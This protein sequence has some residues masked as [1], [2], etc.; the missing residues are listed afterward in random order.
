MSNFIKYKIILTLML[1][2]ADAISK[3]KIFGTKYFK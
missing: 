2:Y 3:L 1:F